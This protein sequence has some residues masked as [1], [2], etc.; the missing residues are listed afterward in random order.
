VHVVPTY[1]PATRYGG[2]IHSV[3][4]LCKAQVRLGHRVEVLTTNLD[5]PGYSDVPLGRAVDVDGVEVT[6]YASRYLRR[7]CWSASMQAALPRRVQSAALLHLHSVFLWPTSAAA[8]VAR[9]YNIP[10]VIAPRGMLVP[11]LIC[12]RS[13]LVKRAWLTLIERH[14]LAHAARFHAT[15]H[16]EYRD[17]ERV[18]LQL[19]PPVVVPN[20]IEPPLLEASAAEFA[21]RRPEFS[22]RPYAVFLGRL[23]WKKGLDRLVRALRGTPIRVVLVGG[24]ELGHRQEIEKLAVAEGVRSQLEFVGHID[25]DDRFH[26]LQRARFLVLPSYNEN[27]GNA[28]TEALCVGC[29]AVVTPEVG[30]SEFVQRAGAGFV[31]SG[32]PGPLS[33]AMLSLWSDEQ[34]RSSMA[35]AAIRV[36]RN[37]L[38]WSRVAR[39]MDDVYQ[40]ILRERRGDLVTN[41][42]TAS[43][44]T[45]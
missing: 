21:A 35:Q 42:P 11:E 27:F 19:P 5:G 1:L 40:E 45:V 36:A 43:N 10:Y 28:V 29:P 37:E 13:T 24:D 2:P 16:A 39:A 34:A 23:S 8:A 38:G 30:A 14:T 3:H 44:L 9:Y 12:R 15:T 26:I 32:E 20:G 31:V 41:G 17:A 25:G 4:G 18:G 22:T 6:Y 33:A 7:L